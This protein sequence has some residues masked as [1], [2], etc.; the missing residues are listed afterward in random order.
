MSGFT[1]SHSKVVQ[2]FQ[3]RGR[4]A[5]RP[6]V[7]PHSLVAIACTTAK[8]QT[9]LVGG[10]E[11]ADIS[12]LPSAWVLEFSPNWQVIIIIGT[13]QH[14]TQCT[15]RRSSLNVFRALQGVEGSAEGSAHNASV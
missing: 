1:V 5:H 3:M 7:G 4:V 10:I 8:F 2:G 13:A 11:D 14:N 6:H 15:L 9:S 12:E